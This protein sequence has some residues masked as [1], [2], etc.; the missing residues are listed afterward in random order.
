MK[1]DGIY[2]KYYNIDSLYISIKYYKVLFFVF[3]YYCT[4]ISENNGKKE[5]LTS[6]STL[7][8]IYIIII[9]LIIYL[10]RYAFNKNLK[11]LYKIQFFFTIFISIIIY[12]LLIMY[13]ISKV[14]LILEKYNCYICKEGNVI[15]KCCCCDESSSICKCCYSQC[16]K[17]YCNYCKFPK[18]FNL[19]FGKSFKKNDE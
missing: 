2:N 17:K 5:L 10:I 18:V 8:T 11:S 7:V 4:N 14:F 1:N 6:Q 12:L 16:C 19:S 13:L 15:C 3:N 9:N